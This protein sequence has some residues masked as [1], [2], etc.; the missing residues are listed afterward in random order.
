M[1]LY[2]DL[3]II[4]LAIYSTNT[5]PIESVFGYIKKKLLLLYNEEIIRL[6]S[7]EVKAKVIKAFKF[8]KEDQTKAYFTKFYE[9]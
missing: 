7:K 5:S 4:F 2:L 9:Y 6:K 1:F 3:K 8:L